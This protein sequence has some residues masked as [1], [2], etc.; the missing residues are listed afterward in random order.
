MKETKIGMVRKL[1]AENPSITAKEVASKLGI[2][3]DYAYGILWKIKQTKKPKKLGRPK[4]KI[5][6]SANQLHIANELG[7]EPAVYAR[8]LSKGHKPDRRKISKLDSYIKEKNATADMLYNLT[9]GRGRPRMKTIAVGISDSPM[10]D[11]VNHPA[12]YK[13]GGIET[14]DFIEAK[15]LS[16][17]LGNVVKYITRADHKGS[18]KMDLEKARWYLN[19]ELENLSKK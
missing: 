14:I 19:R 7:I 10:R 15:K 11:M 18:R 16:Y 3:E 2:K 17:N 1:L 8:E 9:I 5:S 6:L 4:K 13:V 12:H